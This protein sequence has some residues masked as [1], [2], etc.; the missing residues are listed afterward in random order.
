MSIL[1]LLY[2]NRFEENERQNYKGIIQHL[3]D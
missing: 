3:I 2:F 1:F